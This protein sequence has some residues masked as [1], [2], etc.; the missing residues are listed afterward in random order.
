MFEEADAVCDARGF[1]TGTG[2]SGASAEEG[3]PE[4]ALGPFPRRQPRA[5]APSLGAAGSGREHLLP[6]AR[7]AS[8]LISSGYYIRCHGEER[9]DR[10]ARWG[11]RGGLPRV[12]GRDRRQ[13]PA[14]PTCTPSAPPAGAARAR[15]GVVGLGALTVVP[16][17]PL[18]S[19]PTLE[20]RPKRAIF[21]PPLLLGLHVSDSRRLYFETFV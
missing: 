15:A 16:G 4:S 12:A 6:A 13:D 9:G 7:V 18:P 5:R 3:R 21:S 11:G 2:C 20:Q 19:P 17:A 10:E 8:V 14:A 1:L